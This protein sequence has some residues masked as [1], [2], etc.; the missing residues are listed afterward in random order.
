LR[1]FIKNIFP[2]VIILEIKRRCFS[3]LRQFPCLK[4]FGKNESGLKPG[5]VVIPDPPI[6]QG[7]NVMNTLL[8]SALKFHP[9]YSGLTANT[10]ICY[11][12]GKKL[13]ACRIV[14]CVL[15]GRLLEKYVR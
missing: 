7:V 3:S 11:R 10:P 6:N 1:N 4:F 14:A 12:D 15:A 13:P 9:E 5:R 2:K 8:A